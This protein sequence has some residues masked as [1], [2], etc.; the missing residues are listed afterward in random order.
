MRQINVGVVPAVGHSFEAMFIEK[1]TFFSE[2]QGKNPMYIAKELLRSEGMILKDAAK[3][4]STD[5][6]M[7]LY[8]SNIDLT[9][10]SKFR[11]TVNVY[12][13][14]EPPAVDVTNEADNLIRLK[15][16]FDYIVTWN[17]DLVD[18]DIFLKFNYTV[19][20]FDSLNS[21]PFKERKLLTNIS[22]CKQ[23][24][25]RNELYSKRLE[26]I[27][28]FE[29]FSHKDFEFWG[30][31]W[32]KEKYKTYKGTAVSKIDIYKNYRFA[33]CF[34]NQENLNGYITEKI[35]DC[36]IS[37]IVPV[38]LG[39]ENIEQYIPKECF[40]DFREY[41]NIPELIDFLVNMPEDAYLSYINN[42]ERFLNSEAI[43]AFKPEALAGTIAGLAD[44]KKRVGINSLGIW[45]LKMLKITIR[46]RNSIQAY[47]Y[48][49]ALKRTIRRI[50]VK[51]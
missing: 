24:N 40:I 3:A 36:F 20:F 27:N 25:H 23:S 37:K 5:L 50:V 11:N 41:K 16:Y 13:A 1:N 38:Y 12:F 26:V 17:D 22:G 35:W 43:S 18:G 32:D 4:D 45:N 9:M 19:D 14:L 42:I 44:K 30:I 28:Y 2:S 21:T 6:D 51:K 46:I 8:F 15:N 34:E 48:R 7:V 39:A 10:L 31:G 29:T 49:G 33:I 47:G